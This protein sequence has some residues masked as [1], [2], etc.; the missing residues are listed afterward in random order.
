MPVRA[1]VG[2]GRGGGRRVEVNPLSSILMVGIRCMGSPGW[3]M[4]VCLAATLALDASLLAS[5]LA[6]LL[7]ASR[8]GSGSRLGH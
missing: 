2:T 1:L 7:G 8:L 5:G 3:W 6:L 4:G